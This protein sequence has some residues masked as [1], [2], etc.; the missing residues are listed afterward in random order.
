MDNNTTSELGSENISDRFSD[1]FSANGMSDA[2]KSAK[3][4]AVIRKN[5][6]F[7]DKFDIP[8]KTDEIKNYDIS[9]S[10][11]DAADEIINETEK[12]ADGDEIVT[13]AK[14][15]STSRKPSQIIKNPAD[16]IRY[17]QKKENQKEKKK[18]KSEFFAKNGSKPKNIY[19]E[20]KFMIN[21]KETDGKKKFSLPD[22]SV[23]KENFRLKQEENKKRKRG[24]HRLNIEIKSTPDIDFFSMTFDELED[25]PV[26]PV[27]VSDDIL[28]SIGQKKENNKSSADN[29]PEIHSHI[30][31]YE[32]SEDAESMFSDMND[33]QTTLHSRIIALLVLTVMSAYVVF[34]NDLGLPIFSVLN[35]SVSPQGFIFIQLI[36]GIVALASSFKVILGGLKKIFKGKAD[37]DSM[38]AVVMLSSLVSG[39]MMLTNTRLVE[40]G[41]LHI[42]ITVGIAS[43]LF[44]TI[45]KYLIVDRAICNFDFVSDDTK[46]KYAMFCI[47]D[48]DRAERITRDFIDDYPVVAASRKTDFLTDFLKYTY[49]TDIADK[50][51]QYAV[52]V[53]MGISLLSALLL[54]VINLDKYSGSIMQACF[55]VFAM[56]MSLCSCFSLSLIVNL[57]LNSVAKEYSETSGLMLGYQSIED[58]YD[59]NVLIADTNMIFPEKTITLGGIKLFSETQID[60]AIID[61]G[62]IAIAGNSILSD[63]FM[64]IADGKKELFRNVESCVYEENLGLCGWINNKRI[65]L[66]NRKLMTAHNIDKLTSET[67]EKEFNDKGYDVVYLAVSGNLSALF[68]INVTAN[69]EVKY[70]LSEMAEYDFKI[71][72]KNNDAIINTKKLS[73]TFDVPEEYFKIIESRYNDDFNAETKAA[74]KTSASMAHDGDLSTMIKLI[75]DSKNLRRN[76]VICLLMQCA[77]AIIGI[78]F[79]I[80]FICIDSVQYVN[81]TMIMIY[82]L[83]WTLLIS[84]LVKSRI[85]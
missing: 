28:E 3:P 60:E 74:P 20:I 10:E 36:M 42:Y 24:N 69:P 45:G 70:W 6:D 12:N 17:M 23:I 47:D 43:L 32:K 18:F 48:E 82:N 34:A 75:S 55:S 37:C 71:A 16:N 1:E 49:S 57:P 53:F 56:S 81:P 67:L 76:F 7:T 50:F 14:H 27:Y 22:F 26:E 80:I 72:I 38:T 21:N 31:D 78:I 13:Q 41:M 73:E 59:A 85:F 5:K 8:L 63:M 84:I 15:I 19:D 83:A 54:P 2:K 33:L 30:E 39:I 52:P 40:H 68:A 25:N 66:G 46:E 11:S 35:S 79:S 65:L 29:I 62:S 4:E 51:C 9:V 58:F 64:T 77:A 44:N 61:A